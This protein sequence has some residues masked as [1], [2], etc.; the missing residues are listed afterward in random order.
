[1][2]GGGGISLS[3]AG[4]RGCISVVAGGM[5]RVV[6]VVGLGL[7]EQLPSGLGGL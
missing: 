5:L 1:M 4:T 3:G 7:A 2:W 6:A